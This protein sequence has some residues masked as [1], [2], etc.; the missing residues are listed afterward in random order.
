MEKEILMLAKKYE[1]KSEECRKANLLAEHLVSRL[2]RRS[3]I[4]DYLETINNTDLRESSRTEIADDI[5]KTL[6]KTDN[7]TLLSVK[8]H[9]NSLFD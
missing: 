7:T 9:T 2:N 5:L 6:E 4:K 8:Q 3:E 1:V